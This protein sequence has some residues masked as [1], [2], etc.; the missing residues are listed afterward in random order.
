MNK[1]KFQEVHVLEKAVP[2]IQNSFKTKD[3][4]DINYTILVGR[5][6][7]L[8]QE[9]D[10]QWA[11]Y[12]I[13]FFQFIDENIQESDLDAVLSSLQLEDAHWNWFNKSLQLCSGAYKWFYLLCDD[14]VQANCVIYQPRE[15]LLSQKNIFYIEFI[16]VAPWNRKN[17]IR[18]KRYNGIGTLL[19]KSILTYA[20]DTLKLTPG[21]S[22][23]SLPQAT[24]YYEQLGMIH[25]S[26]KDKEKLKYF[27][28]PNDKSIL[29]LQGD[30]T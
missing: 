3:N 20:I 14:K 22:L 2:I 16:A 9:C 15:S 1:I 19:I 7:K 27:E 29:L 12:N 21:F 6:I 11:S 26:E 30:I 24:G 18:D 23:H 17:N 8:T 25:C 13:D 10:Q 4:S 28:I 5:D